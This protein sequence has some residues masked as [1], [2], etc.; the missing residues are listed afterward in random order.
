MG[1]LAVDKLAD[2]YTRLTPDFATQHRDDAAD[3]RLGEILVVA[4]QLDDTIAVGANFGFGTV[5]PE[6][7]IHMGAD[8]AVEHLG[9]GRHARF[10][11]AGDMHTHR[12]HRG[13]AQHAVNAPEQRDKPPRAQ[14][15]EEAQRKHGDE[16]TQHHQFIHTGIHTKE[17]DGAEAELHERQHQHRILDTEARTQEEV[18]QV[19]AVGMEGGTA[20]P[21]PAQHHAQGVDERNRK[22]PEGG[23]RRECANA[24]VGLGEIGEQPGKQETELHAAVVAHETP[25]TTPAHIAQVEQQESRDPR[26]Q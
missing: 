2:F 5:G 12:M 6:T 3:L 8:A 20:H 13:H 14:H 15:D 18:M 16:S 7:E 4:E 21:H 22:Q 11:Q 26:Q 23:D 9:K 17:T 1:I 24:F 19:V 10:G 25:G